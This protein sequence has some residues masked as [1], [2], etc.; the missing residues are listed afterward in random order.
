MRSQANI[1]H[2]F[3][4]KLVTRIAKRSIYRK[5]VEFLQQQYVDGVGN[6]GKPSH[7]VR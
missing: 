5:D 4:L 1:K 3:C 2:G 6:T 7:V